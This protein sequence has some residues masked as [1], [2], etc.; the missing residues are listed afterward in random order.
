LS[1]YVVKNYSLL[2]AVG[3]GAE[4]ED[5]GPL[6]LVPLAVKVGKESSSSVSPRWVVERVKGYYKLIGLSCD[7]YE[8]KLLALFEEIE[9][10]RDH[11]IAETMAMASAV[12]RVKGQREIS[13]W[14]VPLTMIRRGINQIEGLHIK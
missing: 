11:T 9:A 3:E 8:D 5:F 7:R 4:L 10:T 13:G 6:S 2:Q 1:T 14:I 12:S